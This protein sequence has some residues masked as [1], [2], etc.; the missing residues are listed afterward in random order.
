MEGGIIMSQFMNGQSN[1]ILNLSLSTGYIPPSTLNL[2]ALKKTVLIGLRKE[3]GILMS[4][5]FNE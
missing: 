4:Q 5:F 1:W 3:G 2:T